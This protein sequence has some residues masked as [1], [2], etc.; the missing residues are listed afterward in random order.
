[1]VGIGRER[2]DM[3][4]DIALTEEAQQMVAEGAATGRGRNK[5]SSANENQQ[6][7]TQEA[8]KNRGAGE[9]SGIAPEIKAQEGEREQ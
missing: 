8:T 7:M 1:M 9:E 4:G 6:N 2:G 3:V 5:S